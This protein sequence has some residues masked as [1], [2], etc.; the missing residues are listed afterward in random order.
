M[1]KAF[2]Y[3]ITI[4]FTSQLHA[5]PY[6]YLVLEGGGIRGIAYAGALQ[7]LE[8]K[9]VTP[10]IE[11]VAGTS[12]G[13][14]TGLLFSVGYTAAEIKQILFGMDIAVFNDGEDFF[15]GGS[16]RLNKNYGWYKGEELEAWL[17]E[18]IKAKTGSTQTTF[19]QLHVLA[20][21]DKKYKGFY[22]TATNL[23]KQRL[24][25]FSWETHPDMPLKTAVRAS[26]SI[27]LYYGA[28]FIDSVGKVKEQPQGAEHYDVYVDGG[29]LANYPITIF[30]EAGKENT[31][32][33]YTLGLK[34]ER[35]EQLAY[36]KSNT[37][38]A[39]YGIHS[40][41]DYI[42]ALYNITIEQLNKTIPAEV[43]RKHT[44]YI[45]TGGINP[46]VRHISQKEK[47]ILLDSGKQ[48][49][50]QFFDSKN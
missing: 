12:V 26:C 34:L 1:L 3:I 30:N 14:I 49:A 5:Q 37:G 17:G 39:P 40:F 28:V 38:I 18:K 8:E 29:L 32:S 36:N 22:A 2:I 44:I 19:R 6:K 45:S 4:L 10:G 46:R 33:E 35:P 25:V 7:V 31:I 21:A 27:P 50:Q 47:Q 16:I 43:E 15:I 24:E 48:G 41:K 9:N 23:S 20:L 13:A 42:A 11:K